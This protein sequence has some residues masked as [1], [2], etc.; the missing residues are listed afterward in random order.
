MVGFFVWLNSPTVNIRDIFLL[1]FIIFFNVVTDAQLAG[2]FR[3]PTAGIYV[4]NPGYLGKYMNFL[5]VEIFSSIFLI[6]GYR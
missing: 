1:L 4:V 6:L 5:T 3:E 2:I